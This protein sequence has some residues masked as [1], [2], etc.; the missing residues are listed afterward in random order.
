MLSLH[1]THKKNVNPLTLWHTIVIV[2][3]QNNAVMTLLQQIV[4]RM[5]QLEVKVVSLTKSQQ[6]WGR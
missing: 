5:D 1:L 3:C 6:G 2:H 4:D